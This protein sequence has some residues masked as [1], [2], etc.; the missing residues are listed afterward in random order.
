MLAQH[1]APRR[2]LNL[3]KLAEASSNGRSNDS[4]SETRNAL[5]PKMTGGIISDFERC[6]KQTCACGRNQPDG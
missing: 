1:P 5:N 2:L 3:L 4:S 6:P